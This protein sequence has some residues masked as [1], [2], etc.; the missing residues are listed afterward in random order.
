MKYKSTLSLLFVFLVATAYSQI[1]PAKPTTSNPSITPSGPQKP[2][3]SNPSALF[4]KSFQL[5]NG[6]SAYLTPY[7][8]SIEYCS[9][10]KTIARKYH[11]NIVS[12]GILM[13]FD[14]RKHDKELLEMM[15]D[16]VVGLYS[17][18]YPAYYRLWGLF[19]D[20]YYRKL[21]K[22]RDLRKFGYGILTDMLVELCQYLPKDYKTKLV[23]ELKEVQQTIK[24]C[25][26]H[27]YECVTNSWG[28]CDLYVDGRERDDIA[29]TLEGMIARRIC[30]DGIPANE[31]E[32]AVNSILGKVNDVVTTNNA[33]VLYKVTINNELSYCLG[34]NGP[35]FI[36]ERS[37]KKT[38]P[39]D[40]KENLKSDY[41]GQK[42]FYNVGTDGAFYKIR[43]ERCY[44]GRWSPLPA[45]FDDVR[46]LVIN[47]EGK[48]IYKNNNNGRSR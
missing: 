8:P 21:V 27:R 38:V 36:S 4:Y 23:A 47:A 14:I 35:Y 10:E 22:V 6:D 15:Q 7:Y 1:T 46:E 3:S 12:S 24:K 19:Y 41:Y 40:D 42:V 31:L 5:R 28:G 43:N 16:E 18:A 33:D 45:Y 29:G 30:M 20:G 34:I 11:D 17:A 39:F 44:D 2:L 25:K 48:L 9:Y 32:E 37:R 13:S 26:K